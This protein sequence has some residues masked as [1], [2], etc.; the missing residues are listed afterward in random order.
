VC[1]DSGGNLYV[2]DMVGI[3]LG[4]LII[5]AVDAAGQLTLQC[6]A[7]SRQ[8]PLKRGQLGE[9]VGCQSPGCETLL[10]ANPFTLQA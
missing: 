4:P 6:P 3:E 9:L 8:I 5:T 7:C 2:I 1:G 10:R